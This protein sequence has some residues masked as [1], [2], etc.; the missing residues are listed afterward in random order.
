MVV[1]TEAGTGV[2]GLYFPH[3]EL[4]LLYHPLVQDEA[5]VYARVTHGAFRAAVLREH[6]VSID[7]PQLVGDCS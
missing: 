7:G 5:F 4:G 1:P 3:V 2:I 6:G